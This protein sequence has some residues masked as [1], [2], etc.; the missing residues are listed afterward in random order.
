MPKKIFL[1]HP[2]LLIT[3]IFMLTG[4]AAK[5][6][7]NYD[8]AL[9]EGLTTSNIAVM[10]FLAFV[11]GGTQ[12][13]TFDQRKYKYANLIGRFDA[14]AIQARTRPVPKHTITDKMNDY[15]SNRG[16]PMLDDSDTPSASAM[17]KISETLV[18]MKNT[19]QKQGITTI[20]VQTFKNQ[21]IIYLDQA[22]TYE[23]FL[24]R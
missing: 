10:E 1:W 6:A 8:R 15:L 4:C 16:V 24:D 23:S 20:E 9:V 7:P 5:L 12:K 18:K 21:V 11:S 3:L 2:L 13:D 17:A 22:L 19:D 14:L